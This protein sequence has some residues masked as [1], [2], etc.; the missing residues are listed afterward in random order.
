MSRV[1]RWLLLTATPIQ[2]IRQDAEERKFDIL[3]VFM[4]DRPG[5]RDDETPFV[6]SDSSTTDRSVERNGRAAEDG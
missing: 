3:L 1:S 4:F 5:R 2:E 6:V